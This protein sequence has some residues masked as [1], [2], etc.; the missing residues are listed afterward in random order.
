MLREPPWTQPQAVERVDE[1]D[2]R[3]ARHDE[4]AG[5]R[6][7]GGKRLQKPDARADAR[8]IPTM[9]TV[10]EVSANY[11]QGPGMRPLSAMRCLHETLCVVQWVQILPG[12]G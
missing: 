3:E 2:D 5:E 11:P 9:Q 4:C 6:S 7:T 8:L 10:G 12:E 1:W